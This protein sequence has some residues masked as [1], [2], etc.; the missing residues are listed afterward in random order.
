MLFNS[1]IFLF[2]FL[3]IALGG[4]AVLGRFGRRS[5][6]GWLALVSILFYAKWKPAFVLVLLGSLFGNF[7]LSRLIASNKE[8]PRTQSFGSLRA[9]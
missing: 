3:P 1:P 6:I 2:F 4:F 9:S 5:A 8:N 7:L